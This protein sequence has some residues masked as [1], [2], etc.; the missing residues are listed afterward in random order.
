MVLKPCHGIGSVTTFP[1]QT[2][3]ITSTNDVLS[4]DKQDSLE[5]ICDLIRLAGEDEDSISPDLQQNN[6]TLGITGRQ[7]MRPQ[8]VSLPFAHSPHTTSR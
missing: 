2:A 6:P 7:M 5:H 8:H 1:K 4:R 3:Q